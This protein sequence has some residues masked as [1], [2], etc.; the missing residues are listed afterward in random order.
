[1]HTNTIWVCSK[2]TVG[3]APFDLQTFPCES[4]TLVWHPETHCSIQERT[5]CRESNASIFC[6]FLSSYLQYIAPFTSLESKENTKLK[7]RKKIYKRQ[8][9]G[10]L[11][12]YCVSLGSSRSCYAVLLSPG[13][14]WAGL[15]AQETIRQGAGNI[16][17]AQPGQQETGLG[18]SLPTG[19]PKAGQ[20]APV[21]AAMSPPK[22]W[23]DG[24]GSALSVIYC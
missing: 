14:V 13:W 20:C 8:I 11:H 3:V 6:A 17:E 1:M 16:Q 24:V 12:M 15:T 7:E 19:Q 4:V 2:P 21:T 9:F 22:P 10:Q 23:A 5:L 18:T